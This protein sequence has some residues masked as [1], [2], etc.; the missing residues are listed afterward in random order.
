MF[1]FVFRGF[2]V[3]INS[4]ILYYLRIDTYI[5]DYIM[6]FLFHRAYL[7]GFRVTLHFLGS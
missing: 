4:I 6:I 1:Y 5:S 2:C 7:G 3:Y